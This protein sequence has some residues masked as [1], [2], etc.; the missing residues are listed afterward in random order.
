MFTVG[1]DLRSH[2]TVHTEHAMRTYSKGPSDIK[3]RRGLRHVHRHER[4]RAIGSL[5]NQKYINTHQFNVK[6]T[7][8]S[9]LHIILA[10]LF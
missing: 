1:W 7:L 5:P 8:L 3:E 2:P 6:G 9:L 10:P 4:S